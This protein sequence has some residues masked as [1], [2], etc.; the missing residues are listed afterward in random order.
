M[1]DTKAGRCLAWASVVVGLGVQIG[2]TTA[3]LDALAD[4]LDALADRLSEV[5]LIV[6]T[7]QAEQASRQRLIGRFE[8][9][10]E[11]LNRVED[12][13]DKR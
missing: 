12:K 5:K 11:R 6:Q 13:L 2:T 9:F 10:E 8:V 7:V 4:R 1:F 3:R